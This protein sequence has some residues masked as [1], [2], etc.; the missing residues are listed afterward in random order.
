MFQW[1]A[2]DVDKRGDSTIEDDNEV[3]RAAL[4]MVPK[5]NDFDPQFPAIHYRMGRYVT[6]N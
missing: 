1:K 5:N 6:I 4:V 3:Q 2:E